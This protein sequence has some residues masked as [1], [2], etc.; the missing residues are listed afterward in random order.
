[1]HPEALRCYMSRRVAGIRHQ[2]SFSAQWGPD[3][4]LCDP[5]KQQ[6]K[7]ADLLMATVTSHTLICA[8]CQ[9]AEA[10]LAAASQLGGGAAANSTLVEHHLSGH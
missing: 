10:C 9:L 5:R 8:I 1:M 2:G 3:G 6:T 4:L 7:P